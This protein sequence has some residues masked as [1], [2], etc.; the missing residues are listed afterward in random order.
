MGGRKIAKDN[1]ERRGCWGELSDD[2]C[3]PQGA[4]QCSGSL[5]AWSWPLAAQRTTYREAFSVSL[6]TFQAS[7]SEDAPLEIH[8]QQA[9]LSRNTE[10]LK[11]FSEL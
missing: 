1:P 8:F 10:L 3:C 4:Q 11:G 7:D 9:E 6:G 5:G 2:L